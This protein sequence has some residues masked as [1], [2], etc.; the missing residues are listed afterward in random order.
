MRGL[1]NSTT[2]RY[3]T[4]AI[5]ITAGGQETFI[6]EGQDKGEGTQL[7]DA[8]VW[9][10]AERRYCLRSVVQEGVRK[11]KRGKTTGLYETDR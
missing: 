8:M 7:S 5:C 10:S 3:A 9:E 2:K 1:S 6:V 4:E 11:G